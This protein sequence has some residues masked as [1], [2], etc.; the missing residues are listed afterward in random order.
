M[1]QLIKDLKWLLS[2][3]IYIIALAFTAACS[4]GF[5]IVT[6]IIGIDD[7]AVELYLADGLEVAMGRW[8]VYLLNKIFHMAEF[9]PFM[10]ELVGVIL[11][12]TG[13]TLFALLLRRLLGEKIGV[14]ACTIFSCIFVSNPIISEVYIYYYHDGVD[15]GYIL[16]ALALFLFVDGMEAVGRKKLLPFMGST[17]LAWVAVGCYESFVI[18]YIIGII[19]V[20][21]LRGIAGT[22]RLTFGYVIKYLSIGALLTMGTVVLRTVMVEALT[23]MLG[24][25]ELLDGFSQVDKRSLLEIFDVAGQQ[26]GIFE[27]LKMLIKRYWVVYC[28]NAI[29]YLPIWSYMFATLVLGIYAVVSAVRRKAVMFPILFAG[30]MFAPF[31]LTLIEGQVHFYRSCQ[32]MPFFTATGV[33]LLYYAVSKCKRLFQLRHGVAGFALILT[34][35]QAALLNESFYVD[36]LKYEDA[37]NTLVRVAWEIENNYGSDIPVVFTGNYS[38]PQ[39]IWEHYSVGYGSKEFQWIARIT[40]L[41]DVHLKEKYYQPFGYS[42]VGEAI[43]PLIQWGFTAFDG[44]NGQLIKFLEMHGYSFA[45]V[46]DAEVLSKAREIGETMP[47]WPGEGS[48][49]LQ[50]GYVLVNF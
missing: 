6:P 4:Y 1:N 28:V 12:C 24:L 16:T 34:F 18:L 47:G 42:Y 19:M 38:T 3:K 41:V 43:N 33:L 32:Y 9:S 2:Q 37:K 7:T 22:D 8:T 29:V 27:F 15:L 49:I 13:A 48:V 26:E 40:D 10:M 30:M 25:Q 36:Y 20:L 31:L 39:S 14:V 21:F 17:L 23:A 50:D 11:L 45:T 35:N 44:T 46:T 5:A